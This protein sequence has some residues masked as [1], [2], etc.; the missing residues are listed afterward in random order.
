MVGVMFEEVQGDYD[1]DCEVQV[2][3]GC[4]YVEGEGFFGCVGGDLCFVYD[5]VE[6]DQ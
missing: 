6:G 1:D 5:F 2:D 4:G 3:G